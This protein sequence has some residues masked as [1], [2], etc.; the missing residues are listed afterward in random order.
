MARGGTGVVTTR[1][2]G[3]CRACGAVCRVSPAPSTQLTLDGAEPVVPRRRIAPRVRC[4]DCGTLV[5]CG[6]RVEAPASPHPCGVTCRMARGA[7]CRCVCEGAH[8][9]VDAVP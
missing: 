2:L 7:E 5:R 8:H 1:Y 4:P 6:V 9:G 3:R